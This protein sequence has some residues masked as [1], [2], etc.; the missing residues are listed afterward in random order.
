MLAF[1]QHDRLV[2][3]VLIGDLLQQV[4]DAVQSGPFLVDAA[5]L[6]PFTS[7]ELKAQRP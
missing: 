1:G 5:A 6:R 7:P 4:M 3:N 2:V